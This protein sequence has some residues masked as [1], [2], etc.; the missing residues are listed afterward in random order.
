MRIRRNEI[1][2]IASGQDAAT[3]YMNVFFGGRPGDVPKNPYRTLR[4][5]GL[6]LNLLMKI[7]QH[8]KRVDWNS[9]VGATGLKY[10]DIVTYTDGRRP[11]ID[12]MIGAGIRN[13]VGRVMK[14][15]LEPVP[16]ADQR[17]ADLDAAARMVRDI[18]SWDLEDSRYAQV[19]DAPIVDD[20][21]TF[22][23]GWGVSR[24]DETNANTTVVASTEAVRCVG[25][26]ALFSSKS[27][28]PGQLGMGGSKSPFLMDE[29]AQR[30]MDRSSMQGGAQTMGVCPMCD[31]GSNLEPYMPS[32][33]EAEGGMDALDRPLGSEVPSCVPAWECL[34][35]HEL[36]PE[37]GGL[38]DT[39]QCRIWGIETP[40][41]MQWCEAHVDP[42]YLDNLSP[43]S[44][45]ELMRTDPLLN[46]PRFSDGVDDNVY[47]D[48]ILTRE[49]ILESLPYGGDGPDDGLRWGR[50]MLMIGD[51][52][53]INDPLER[54]VPGTD[55]RI[56]TVCVAAGV[57]DRVRRRFFGRTPVD[58][59]I[60]LNQR[61]N[62]LDFIEAQRSEREI[63]LLAMPDGVDMYMRKPN[64]G[65]LMNTYNWTNNSAYPQWTP[66]RSVM[67]G[68][69][70]VTG[71][72]N[73]R[74]GI[75][76]AIREI[77]GPGPTDSGAA[78]G[79][80]SAR[81]LIVQAEQAAQK[82]NPFDSARI[83]IHTKLWRHHMDLIWAFRR[84]EKGEYERKTAAGTY[85]KK[86]YEGTELLRQTKVDLQVR[87][88]TDKSL[89]QA[90]QAEKGATLGLY[91][92]E[93]PLTTLDQQSKD[94]VLELLGQP[95]LESQLSVQVT[96]A[97]QT[98]SGF[99][100]NREI[101][102]LDLTVIDSGIWFEVLGKRWLDDEAREIQKACGWDQALKS[103]AGWQPKLDQAMLNDQAQRAVYEGHPPE[104][105][106]QIQA[107]LTAAIQQVNQASLPGPGAPPGMPP[108]QQPP[109]KPPPTP[110]ASGQF[111]PESMCDKL[112]QLWRGMLAQSQQPSLAPQLP[113]EAAAMLPPDH[114]IRQEADKAQELD[115][116]LQF[117][118]VLQEVRLDARAKSAGAPQPA[119]PGGPS[120]PA[121]PPPGQ[122]ASSAQGVVPGAMAA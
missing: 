3:Q 110:P 32:A 44:V 62:Q 45:Q 39:D 30:L 42:K 59:A 11:P 71:N 55:E 2:T 13:I 46:D 12:N 92:G 18:L 22:G 31:E 67:F 33:D 50:R 73:S 43:M 4:M 91:G 93:G 63:P 101:P 107:Q 69:P 109:L 1:P 9:R 86:S 97:E 64:K 68:G 20:L 16:H 61:L 85:E 94:Q 100:T 74:E 21:V 51:R 70:H 95:K 24:L 14:K 80:N 7:G 78:A 116:C 57:A 119:A 84:G 49:I 10:L 120:T 15:E 75:V 87:A 81:Q 38:I 66:E 82:L 98:W 36:H 26:G 41:S 90:E 106:P 35:L 48:H 19:M 40:R 103:L 23:T 72:V 105:W 89:L 99:E 60:P 52:L 102:Y 115:L 54:E 29:G 28:D 25:C 118:A 27:F 108:P 121:G 88:S 53:V 5:T 6:T 34:P 111:L 47:G 17:R 8:W 56:P 37:N 114:P 65:G 76:E 117:Y 113:P 58:D 79:A 77:L 112:L 104:E 83:A 122:E 96:I